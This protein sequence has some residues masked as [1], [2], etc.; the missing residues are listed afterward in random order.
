MDFAGFLTSSFLSKIPSLLPSSRLVS[1]EDDEIMGRMQ[2]DDV[3][4]LITLFKDFELNRS[5]EALETI[6]S[7]LV[8]RQFSCIT[9]EFQKAYSGRERH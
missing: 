2:A 1:M 6:L 9:V 7:D 8:G 3:K 4:K 5:A